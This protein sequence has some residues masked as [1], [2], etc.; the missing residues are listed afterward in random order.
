MTTLDVKVGDVFAFNYKPAIENQLFMPYHC[1][2]GQ[3]VVKQ[4]ENGALYLEDTYWS[5]SSN[6]KRFTIEDALDKG[7][8][9]FK[10]NLDDVR[11]I[12]EKEGG[13]YNDSDL[14]DLSRQHGCYKHLVVRKSARRS[15]TKIVKVLQERIDR[16]NEDIATARNRIRRSQEE[17]ALAIAGKLDEVHL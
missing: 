7:I 4:R 1:F 3:L 16:A 9:K 17:L 11:D 2:D 13:Y 12:T 8:L 14:F 5:N 15:K 10:C 6:N